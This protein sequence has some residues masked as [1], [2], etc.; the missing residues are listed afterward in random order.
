MTPDG[1]GRIFR[2]ARSSLNLRNALKDIYGYSIERIVLLALCIVLIPPAFV[3]YMWWGDIQFAPSVFVTEWL[4]IG[5][6]SILIALTL[7]VL[8]TR[9]DIRRGKI[10]VTEFVDD[11]LLPQF[12]RLL[13]CLYDYHRACGWPKNRLEEYR[14]SALTAKD[15]LVKAID[16][17]QKDEELE[18]VL[19]VIVMDIREIA[20]S[21]EFNLILQSIVHQSMDKAPL[22]DLVLRKLHDQRLNLLTHIHSM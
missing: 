15:D 20:V 18:K 4:K 8:L 7:N 21:V 19:K 14:K 10:H 22:V 5:T 12:T 2:F 11:R 1:I 13:D 16:E 17:A 3:I 6:T 9:R